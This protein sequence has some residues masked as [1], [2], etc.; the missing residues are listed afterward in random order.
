MDS[1]QVE[2]LACTDFD[3]LVSEM[4]QRLERVLI[5]TE[6]VGST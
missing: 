6:K 2:S 5:K 1:N 4:N 3:D